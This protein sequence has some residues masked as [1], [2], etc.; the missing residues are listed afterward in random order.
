MRWNFFRDVF[1]GW[2]WEQMD[3]AGEFVRESPE[4]FDTREEAE[5][6]A[7]REGYALQDA[8]LPEGQRRWREHAAGAEYR[9]GSGDRPDRPG[10]G[11]RQQRDDTV[12]HVI[13]AEVGAAK[14]RGGGVGDG[15]ACREA[16]L[17]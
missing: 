15:D 8:A 1:G 7:A 3:F 9:A 5:C 13:P 4:H 2:G 17:L 10:P 14:K 6:D 16:G 12:D 11:A